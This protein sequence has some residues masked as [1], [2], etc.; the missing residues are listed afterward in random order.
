[1][2]LACTGF[3]LQIPVV[4]PKE[5]LQGVRWGIPLSSLLFHAGRHTCF[6]LG[7]IRASALSD[8]RGRIILAAYRG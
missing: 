8:Q 7:V 6:M 2:A 1:V 5:R 4:A 3:Y